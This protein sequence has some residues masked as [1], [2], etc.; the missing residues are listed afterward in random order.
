MN[1]DKVDFERKLED[2]NLKLDKEKY[3]NMNFEFDDYVCDMHVAQGRMN[4]K[5]GADFANE[6]SFVEDMDEKFQNLNFKFFKTQTGEHTHITQI[7]HHQNG[8]SMMM[9]NSGS[10][11]AREKYRVIQQGSCR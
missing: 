3:K 6:G 9:K 4:G 1:R 11:N 10:I 5:N 8:S 7:H 2:I